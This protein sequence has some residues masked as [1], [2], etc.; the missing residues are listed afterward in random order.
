MLILEE[1]FRW[2]L[3]AFATEL[4][5]SRFLDVLP[6]GGVAERRGCGQSVRLFCSD[7]RLFLLLKIVYSTFKCI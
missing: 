6:V 2:H 3:Q 5:I 7:M 4:F 1:G